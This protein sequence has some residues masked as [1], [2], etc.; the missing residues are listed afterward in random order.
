MDEAKT[1]DIIAKFEFHGVTGK[2]L[3]ELSDIVL[4]EDMNIA[5]FGTRHF[6]LESVRHLEWNQKSAVEKIFAEFYS[7]SLSLKPQLSFVSTALGAFSGVLSL[8]PFIFCCQCARQKLMMC[9][10]KKKFVAKPDN[11]E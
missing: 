3:L 7:T 8:L 11:N 10:K 2:I 9:K 4:K 5:S 1:Q 6:I